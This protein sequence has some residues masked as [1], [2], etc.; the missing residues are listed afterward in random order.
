[1][2]AAFKVLS[3]AC[4]RDTLSDW[5]SCQFLELIF[6]IFLSWFYDFDNFKEQGIDGLLGFDVIKEL[7][8]ELKGREGLLIVQNGQPAK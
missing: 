1:M 8:I 4:R 6:I 2:L 7:D 3:E 5:R